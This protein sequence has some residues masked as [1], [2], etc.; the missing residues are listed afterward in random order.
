ML[1]SQFIDFVTGAAVNFTSPAPLDMFGALGAMYGIFKPYE[2][3]F[4]PSYSQFPAPAS[5]PADLLLPFGEFVT[6]YHL[7]AAVPKIFEITGHGV[8]DRSTP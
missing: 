5:I 1:P 2:R 3:L 8:G 7:E 4:T 6:K